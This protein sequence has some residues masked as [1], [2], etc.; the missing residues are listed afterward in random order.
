MPPFAPMTRLKNVPIVAFMSPLWPNCPLCR[1]P[2][3]PFMSLFPTPG[4]RVCRVYVGLEAPYRHESF[5]PFVSPLGCVLHNT[6][7]HMS[8]KCPI[9]KGFIMPSAF[10]LFVQ[11][12]SGFRDRISRKCFY[13]KCVRSSPQCSLQGVMAPLA[14]FWHLCPW[15]TP[16]APLAP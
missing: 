7:S 12:M 6:M 8:H 11:F 10:V 3:E 9:C 14:P 13:P 16:M 4:C 1:K 5:E 2:F 15:W